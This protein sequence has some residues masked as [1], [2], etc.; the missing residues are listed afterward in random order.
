M[1][2]LVTV[3]VIVAG[4]VE[5]HVGRRSQR[6]AGVVA[7]E[8]VLAVHAV[9]HVG[10]RNQQH[11]GVVPL[12]VVF[13]VHVAL[14]VGRRSWH[15]A[16]IVTL[17]QQVLE[18]ASVLDDG[19]GK[20]V[21][22][23]LDAVN[24]V[25]PFVR[26]DEEVV[27][28]ESDQCLRVGGISVVDVRLGPVRV[29]LDV[30]IEDLVRDA[31]RAVQSPR[32]VPTSR[33]FV[34]HDDT[35]RHFVDI[36]V[37]CDIRRAV[38]DGERAPMQEAAMMLCIWGSKIPHQ[39]R[40]APQA[41]RPAQVVIVVTHWHIR[42]P[43]APILGLARPQCSEDVSA[44]DLVKIAFN[45]RTASMDLVHGFENTFLDLVTRGRG[46]NFHGVVGDFLEVL[47]EL[48]VALGHLRP[49]ILLGGPHEVT[50]ALRDVNFV[51]V[52]GHLCETQMQ[53]GKLMM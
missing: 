41:C 16:G 37:L 23:E 10:R 31:L 18:A 5:L 40:T 30:A 9:L 21:L 53:F 15:Q 25:I 39:G 42:L 4:R 34:L 45:E 43:A 11:A 33:P 3:A 19:H 47:F 52:V 2:K 49:S 13:A 17:T 26:M 24:P 12:A 6:Q 50:V 48:R 36:S 1:L 44:E 46:V 22:S 7:V 28:Q 27:T 20:V 29:P 35:V 8:V 51:N 38:I 32:D 14:Q